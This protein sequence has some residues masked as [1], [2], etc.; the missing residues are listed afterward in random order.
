[1]LGLTTLKEKL[2][3]LFETISFPLA[4][5]VALQHVLALP[6]VILSCHLFGFIIVWGS[7]LIV[8]AWYLVRRTSIQKECS[9]KELSLDLINKVE[10]RISSYWKVSWALIIQ[11]CSSKNTQLRE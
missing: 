8:F 2:L 1:M 10:Y 3:S 7:M 4:G 11:L 5:N 9:Q 6:F